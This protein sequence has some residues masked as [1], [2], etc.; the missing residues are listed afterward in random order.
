MLSSDDIAQG[1]PA[2]DIYLEITRRLG[3]KAGEIA[4]FED[5]ANGILAGLSAGVKV[6]AVPGPYHRPS[7]A[8]LQSADLVLQSLHDFSPEMLDAL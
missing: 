1:K 2:P 7:D 3:V 8:V 5:S 6:I 4:I